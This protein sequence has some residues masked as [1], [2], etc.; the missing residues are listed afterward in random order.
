MGRE[1]FYTTENN[2]ARSESASEALKL[3]DRTLQSWVGHPKIRIVKPK[4]SVD[5]KINEVLNII[6]D[7]LNKKQVKR[8]EKYSVDLKKT[9]LN[10]VRENGKVASIEQT[11]LLADEGT[12]K[13]V[14]K[15]LF[16]GSVSYVLSVYK[17]QED[18]SK[19]IIFEKQIDE[20]MYKSLLEFKDDKYDV[21]NKKRYYFTYDGE[22]FYLDI[23]ADNNEIGILEINVLENEVVRIPEFIATIEN[24]T[25]NESYYNK[26]IALK[27]GK[28]LKKK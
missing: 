8:Q 12:E 16:N 25:R 27:K 13:R 17:L 18:G 24:V 5:E 3:G 15:V 7:L 1:D 11:Y 2:K 26:R 10:Y 9:D 14:R 6:N 4:D 28:R 21:I 23:F 22:Y 20:S 19:V